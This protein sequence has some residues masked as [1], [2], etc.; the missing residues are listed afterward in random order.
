[1]GMVT[2]LGFSPDEKDSRVWIPSRISGS[3]DR[4]QSSRDLHSWIEKFECFNG[5]D[6]VHYP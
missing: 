5:L 2:R 3:R 6:E 1:M 4:N